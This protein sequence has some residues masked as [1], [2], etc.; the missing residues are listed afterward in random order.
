MSFSPFL[1]LSFYL[2]SIPFAATYQCTGAVATRNMDQHQHNGSRFHP[3]SSMAG[4]EGEDGVVGAVASS[5][6]SSSSSS[7]LSASTS[8]SVSHGIVSD[9]EVDELLA[10]LVKGRRSSSSIPPPPPPTTTSANYTAAGAATGGG[11]ETAPTNTDS[12]S[13]NSN[14]ISNSSSSSSSCSS[15]SIL[16]KELEKQLNLSWEQGSK[17]KFVQLEVKNEKQLSRDKHAYITFLVSAGCSSLYLLFHLV[18]LYQPTLSH[19]QHT[20]LYTNHHFKYVS[21]GFFEGRAFQ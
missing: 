17:E 1:S 19:V 10:S 16:R 3:A 6:S 11:G 9:E 5:S 20:S 7:S 14:N 12:S 8:A 21:G 2:P 15:S 18:Y 4:A 13:S